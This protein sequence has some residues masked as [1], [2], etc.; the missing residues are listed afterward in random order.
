MKKHI[1]IIDNEKR[2]TDIGWVSDLEYAV[3]AIADVKITK[4]H[5]S[6]LSEAVVKELDPDYIICYGRVVEHWDMEEI[7]RD[8]RAELEFIKNTQIPTLGI[9]AGLQLTAIAHG[10]TVDRMIESD[11]EDIL[12]QGFTELS[13]V[14]ED[15]LLRGLPDRF[16]CYELHR[17]EAKRVPLGFKLLAGNGLCK[18]QMIKSLKAPIYGVQFHPEKYTDE[19]PHGKIIL[20]NFLKLEKNNKGNSYEIYD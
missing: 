19:Y 8:Y 14:E 17:D 18:V 5:H 7:L 10:V 3:L 20:Q 12:E 6:K 16:C 9:C 1:L 15:A 2:E 4:L 11:R 13:V